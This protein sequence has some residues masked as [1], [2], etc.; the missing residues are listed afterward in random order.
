MFRTSGLFSVTETP[1]MYSFFVVRIPNG[2]RTL[3]LYECNNHGYYASPYLVHTF[4]ITNVCI[5]MIDICM[6]L[7]I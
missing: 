2:F 5:L 4:T 7:E 6:H 3:L 1:R